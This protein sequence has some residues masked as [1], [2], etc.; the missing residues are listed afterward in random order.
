MRRISLFLAVVAFILISSYGIKSFS[1]RINYVVPSYNSPLG[2]QYELPVKFL[3]FGDSRRQVRVEF[4]ENSVASRVRKVIRDK[5]SSMDYSFILHTG[6]L[7][8]IGSSSMLW[9]EFDQEYS[10]LHEKSVPFYPVPGNHE[11]KYNAKSAMDN[12]FRRFRGLNR[13]KW[14]S[15]KTGPMAF[16]MLDSNLK[17]LSRD[18]QEKQQLWYLRTLSGLQ[19]DKDIRAVSV[20]FHHTPMTNSTAHPD[21]TGA[22]KLFLKPAARYDKVRLFFVGHVHSY[23]RFL[24]NNIMVIVTGGGGAPLYNVV[25]GLKHEDIAGWPENKRGHNFLQCVLDEGKVSC[26]VYGLEGTVW[27]IVDEFEVI[28]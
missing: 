19:K 14:Y 16:V 13:S 3:V 17:K 1:D 15:F 6:D 4:P 7:V 8:T 18:E 28:F 22:R 24:Y 5:I 20:V 12:Y 27:N 23:E 11:Y 21:D 26:K 10:F 2:Q 25:E 9:R